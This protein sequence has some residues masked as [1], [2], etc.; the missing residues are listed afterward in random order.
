[1]EEDLIQKG[2]VKLL[3][4]D[5]ISVW[6]YPTGEWYYVFKDYDEILKKTKSKTNAYDFFDDIIPKMEKGKGYYNYP[7]CKMCGGKCCTS[8]AGIYRPNDLNRPITSDLI[9]DLL[10]SGKYSV[11]SWVADPKD[12]MFIRPKHAKHSNPYM[13]KP[14]GVYDESWGGTCIHWD[15][16]LGC[17]LS[18]EERPYQCRALIPGSKE[19]LLPEAAKAGKYDLAME[20]LPYEKEINE[21]LHRYREEESEE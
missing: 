12:I 3:E 16:D 10:K 6:E 9:L 19:C 20:W 8:Y 13:N 5:D 11:D 21:A 1:M 15:K 18:E 4:V 14:I 2:F 7:R 17:L